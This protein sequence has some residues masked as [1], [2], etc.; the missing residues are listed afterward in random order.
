VG[1]W[2][3]VEPRA[4]KR[5][6]KWRFLHY[7]ETPSERDDGQWY[8]ALFF[9]NDERSTFGKIEFTGR[10]ERHDFRAIATKL[11]RDQAYRTKYLSNDPE[12]PKLWRRR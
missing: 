9:R 8:E 2:Y 12:L 11:Q 5:D 3:A 1:I 7:I 6:V 4:R 10:L